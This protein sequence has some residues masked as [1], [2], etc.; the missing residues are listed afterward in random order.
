MNDVDILF[1]FSVVTTSDIDYNVIII[2]Y[3]YDEI[4]K[5]V[6][7]KKY[8]SIVTLKMQQ[9]YQSPDWIALAILID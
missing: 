5:Y 9:K 4:G 8:F 7:Q 6:M 3:N 1:F 2:L